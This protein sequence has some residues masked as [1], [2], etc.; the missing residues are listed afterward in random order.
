MRCSCSIWNSA[1]FCLNSFCFPP[2]NLHSETTAMA[3]NIVSLT[4]W[5]WSSYAVRARAGGAVAE[6]TTPSI[7]PHCM[8]KT[9]PGIARTLPTPRRSTRPR[10]GAG[11]AQL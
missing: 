8:M 1:S 4:L 10:L 3:V 6:R 2:T 9:P 7:M 11:T 5:A